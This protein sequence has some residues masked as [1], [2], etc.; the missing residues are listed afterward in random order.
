MNTGP[1]TTKFEAGALFLVGAVGTAYSLYSFV[2]QTVNPSTA[3]TIYE[4]E[5]AKISANAL[6][7][8]AFYSS[9]TAFATLGLLHDTAIGNNLIDRAKGFYNMLS[10]F[11]KSNANVEPSN[12]QSCQGSTQVRRFRQ[13]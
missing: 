5:F 11:K 13:D 9:L 6:H 4:P 7:M 3:V 2:E 1:K 8:A 10:N 12:S